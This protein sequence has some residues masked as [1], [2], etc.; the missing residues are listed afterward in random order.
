M[1]KS[2]IKPII[3]LHSSN[4]FETDQLSVLQ[5]WSGNLSQKG[6]VIYL[7]LPEFAPK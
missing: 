6:K 7:T 3:Y 2:E 1:S 4:D 5:I